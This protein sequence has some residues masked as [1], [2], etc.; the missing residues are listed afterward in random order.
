M[1]TSLMTAFVAALLAGCA[2]HQQGQSWWTL[3]EQSFA[4]IKPGTTSKNDVQ[5]DLGTPLL[6][7]T[8]PRLEEEVW[9]YRYLNGTRTY[10]AELHFDAQGR[11]KYVATYPDHCVQ[12]PMPCR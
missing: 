3:S 6:A 7:M 12:H 1:K 8:F 4:S 2:T 10:V 9:D 11:T 5:R